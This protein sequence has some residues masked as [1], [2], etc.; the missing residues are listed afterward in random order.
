M[1]IFTFCYQLKKMM[2]L[3]KVKQVD[4]FINAG[5]TDSFEPTDLSVKNIMAFANAYKHDKSDYLGDV[6]YIIN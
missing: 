1:Q 6:D 3:K 2:G 4:D 5:L